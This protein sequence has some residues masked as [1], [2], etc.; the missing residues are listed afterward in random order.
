MKWHCSNKKLHRYKNVSYVIHLQL[1]HT[2]DGALI[3]ARGKSDPITAD[4]NLKLHP[5]HWSLPINPRFNTYQ[6]NVN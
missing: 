6:L 5:I 3:N 1:L 4:W 2:L